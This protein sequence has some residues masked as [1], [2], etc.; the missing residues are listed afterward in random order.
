VCS[1]RFPG[2]ELQEFIICA[3]CQI[4]SHKQKFGGFKSDPDVPPL[5]RRSTK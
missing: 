1:R 2:V 3:F 4:K 5:S